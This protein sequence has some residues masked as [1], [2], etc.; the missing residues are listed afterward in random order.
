M[1]ILGM[2]VHVDYYTMHDPVRGTVD[3]APHYKSPKSDVVRTST[4]SKDKQ[5][6]A[7]APQ[8][9]QPTSILL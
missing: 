1:N 9:V 3:W 6:K 4:P 2:P 7:V 8:Q 5:L